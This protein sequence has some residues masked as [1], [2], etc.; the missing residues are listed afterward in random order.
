MT[1]PTET[2]TITK[3]GPAR[4]RSAE[5]LIATVTN[6]EFGLSHSNQRRK[7]FS[8]RNKT[9]TSQKSASPVRKSPLPGLPRTFCPPACA[10]PASSLNTPAQAYRSMLLIDGPSGIWLGGLDSN[11]DNQIQSLMYC[12]LY[13]LPSGGTLQ[14]KPLARLTSTLLADL[15]FVNRTRLPGNCVS[16]VSEAPIAFVAPLQLS[17]ASRFPLCT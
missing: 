1:Q 13:D 9:G 8:N 15:G 14:K 7:Q 12:Q 6:S 11:Q 4:T 3:Q 10:K 16:R 2:T 5:F 17:F